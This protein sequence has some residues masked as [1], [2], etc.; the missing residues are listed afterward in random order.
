ML[1]T[2]FKTIKPIDKSVETNH[3]K[4]T[5]DQDEHI[6]PLVLNL[7]NQRMFTLH[8]QQSI[9]LKKGTSCKVSH[10]G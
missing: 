3:P 1:N 5:L 10:L 4:S 8:S 9:I 2:K 7:F 6:Q